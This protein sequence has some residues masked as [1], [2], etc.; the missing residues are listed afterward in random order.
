[1]RKA[2]TMDNGYRVD[3]KKIALQIWIP[4]LFSTLKRPYTTG[5]AKYLSAS[6][7]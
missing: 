2:M 1:M 5:K 4:L 3:L 7:N 6:K